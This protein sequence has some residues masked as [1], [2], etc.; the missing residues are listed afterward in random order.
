MYR[1]VHQGFAGT[2]KLY[3]VQ[4]GLYKYVKDINKD[5]YSSIFMYNEEH[6]KQL[7]QTG[8][9]AGVEGVETDLL[10]FD[11]DSHTDLEK[12]RHEALI[13]SH[14]LIDKGI[15]EQ[16][17]NIAFSGSKGFSITVKLNKKL[18]LS[19]FKSINLALADG[20][21]TNDTKIL[22]SNRIFRIT[23]T[24]HH[25]S[26]LFKFPLTLKELEDCPVSIIKD[27]ASDIAHATFDYKVQKTVD[28]PDTI[29]N[30]KDFKKE[31]VTPKVVLDVSDLDFSKKPKGFTNCKF[32]LLEGFYT[33]G[34]R[35]NA[36]LTLV[37]TCRANGYSKE[38]AYNMAKASI[39]LQATRYGQSA[40]DKKELWLNIVSQI[41]RPTWDG[42][43]FSCKKE[44]WLR[45]YCQGLG[46]NTCKHNEDSS[47]V[48][49]SE[50]FNLF[51]NYATNFEKNALTTGIKGLDERCK[52]M[53]GTSNG[54]LAPPGVGKTSLSLSVLNYNS[55]QKIP[56]IFFSY[57][58][59][60]PMLYL[61]L[62]QKHTGYNQEKVFN[63]FKNKDKEAT[64]I[65]DLLEEEYKYVNFCFKSGQT[66]DEIENTIIDTEQKIGNKI[67]LVIVDYNELVIANT[68]DPTQASAQVA[69]R[70]RQ[71]SNDREVAGITLLQP[72]KLYSDPSAEASSYQA[73]KGSGAIAQSL[74]LMLSLSRPGFS[75]R[76]PD[77]DRF[78]SISALKN[79]NGGLFAVDL[80]WEGLTGAVGE[81]SDDDRYE[82]KCLREKKEIEKESSFG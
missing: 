17:I 3:P 6:K 53:V 72:A 74:T 26:G 25:T 16:A 28:L 31:V 52:F 54:I 76:N 43:Q 33:S 68:S 58:M 69:Q 2:R 32:S 7:E 49:T 23:G 21:E 77:Q 79:R 56:S 75:P 14:R 34:Q 35:N 59:T 10:A 44:G 13:L 15:D 51:E 71:I 46:R 73:A 20:L 62:V 61:R 1:V 19:E 57:D 30:L 64:R 24:K 22:D 18:T 27:G 67:K 5:Y 37:A 80:S 29:Y 39:R 70:M 81:L 4:D 65:K 60:S 78:L 42:G 48:H 45:D 12:T 41:Y 47:T 40:F 9:L 11:L 38:I 50:V 8:S 63:I 36:L 82:L 66:P 55:K